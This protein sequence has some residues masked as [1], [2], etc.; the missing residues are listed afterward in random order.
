MVE[1]LFYFKTIRQMSL[2]LSS[3]SKI[4]DKQFYDSMQITVQININTCVKEYW[5]FNCKILMCNIFF[6][7]YI[8]NFILKHEFN[9]GS[10]SLWRSK[11][12]PE[13]HV[14]S[15]Y[16][17]HSKYIILKIVYLLHKQTWLDWYAR[18]TT[19]RQNELKSIR[20]DRL[21]QEKY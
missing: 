16:L 7:Q 19:Y 9:K 21:K 20:I 17:N 3:L 4:N 8:W 2:I 11:V 14:C 13:K 12:S 18:K 15:Q 10:T 1:T 5:N 6:W